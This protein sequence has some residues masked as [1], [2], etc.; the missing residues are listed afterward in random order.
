[1]YPETRYASNPFVDESNRRICFR[2][3]QFR[4]YAE[5]L[6]IAS[7]QAD[8]PRTSAIDFLFPG[9]NDLLS[10]RLTVIG[11]GAT[12]CSAYFLSGSKMWRVFDYE[13]YRKNREDFG[14]D[15]NP[16]DSA[17]LNVFT[18]HVLP[19]LHQ[20]NIPIGFTRNYKFRLLGSEKLEIIANEGKTSDKDNL[21]LRFVP[22]VREGIPKDILTIS[23]IKKHWSSIQLKN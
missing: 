20:G 11:E 7:V 1:M 19:F 23:R 4:W 22:D 3:D 17:N 13:M 15:Q 14:L 8:I 2:I 18:T 10:A 16:I 21:I 6:N 12:K 5:G 9:S